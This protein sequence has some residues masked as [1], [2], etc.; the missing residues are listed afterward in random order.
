MLRP[1][2]EEVGNASQRILLAIRNVLAF[3]S[4]LYLDEKGYRGKPCPTFSSFVNRFRVVDLIP[5]FNVNVNG[6][7]RT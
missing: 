4:W 6:W 7:L 5:D 2:E 1:E 3:E